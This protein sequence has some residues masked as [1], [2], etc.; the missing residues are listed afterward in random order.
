V[1]FHGVFP[2]LVSPLD[3]SGEVNARV[4]EQVPRGT[5]LEVDYAFGSWFRVVRPEG[6]KWLYQDQAQ[7]LTSAPQESP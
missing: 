7:R 1:D 2:Y 4:L 3:A 5:V 6:R